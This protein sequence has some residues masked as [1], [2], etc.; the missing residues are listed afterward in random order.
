MT[1]YPDP[2]GVYRIGNLKFYSKLEAIEF[3][4]R[5]GQPIH[6]DFNEAVFSSYDWTKEP[7]ESLSELYRQRAQQLRD[8]YD[9][10]VLSYSGGSDS[11]NILHSFIDNDIKIDEVVSQINVQGTGDRNSWLNE[12]IYKTAI[13]AVSELQKKQNFKYRLVD[14]TPIELDFFSTTENRYDWIY[15]M[16]MSW[17]PNNVSRKNW[18]ARIAEWRTI[19]DS[20]KKLCIVCG[21]DKPRIAHIDGKFCVRFSDLID[22]AATANSAAGNQDYSDELFYWTP[23]LPQLVIKQAHVIKNYFKGDIPSL[24]DVG[25]DKSDVAFCEYQGSKYWLSRDGMSR[26][27]YP[28]WTP[29][30]V[31]CGKPPSMLFSNRDTWFFAMQEQHPA[32]QAWAMGVDK[33]WKTLPN[34][35]KNSP[36]EITKGVKLCISPNYW[37]D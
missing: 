7:S 21:I 3:S 25:L 9:Y 4:T 14:L 16:S 1:H 18:P 11:D 28:T 12:E 22:V 13:P 29:G 19:I 35:W 15:Q 20:G 30:S 17:T 10:I 23:D 2:L 31:V 26:L 36:K 33:L 8:R 24:P 37:L 32:K 27:M 34:Y 6:W 5:T